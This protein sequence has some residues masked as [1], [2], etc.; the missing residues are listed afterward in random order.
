MSHFPTIQVNLAR[1]MAEI[2]K[3]A[4]FSDTPAPSVTR[5][6]YTTTD[7]AARGYLKTL[8]EEAGF[9]WRTDAMGNTFIRWQGSDP[10]LTA[11]ATGSHI[12]AIPY[13]GRYD[14]VVGVLGGIEALRCLKEGGFVPRRSLEVILFTAE[15]PTRFGVGCIGSRT[16]A[17]LY[18]PSQ[19]RML[20]DKDGIAFDA[21]RHEAG[22]VGD[23]AEVALAGDSY[24]WFVE[25]HIEQAPRL[26][27]AQVPIGVVV[28]VVASTT[29]RVIFKGDGGHA[30]TV[31]M[32]E[33]RDALM[34]AAELALMAEAIAKASGSPDAVT[35]VGIFNVHPGAS[36]SIP[37]QVQMTVDLRDTEMR[38]RDRMLQEIQQSVAEISSRRRVEAEI[39]IFNS[40]P[41]CR[42]HPTIVNA[43]QQAAE[44]LRLAHIPLT[45]RAYHDTVFMGQI[46]PV[47]MIFIPSA[48]GYSHR[49]EEFSSAQEIAQGV[50]VLALTL[51]QLTET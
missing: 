37:S 20:Q 38:V 43:I 11:V 47:A 40:D 4:E 17:G 3:L 30:G 25:L 33:R 28:G 44:Q 35:T 39:E 9:G 22:F 14:G 29:L 49:P 8:V 7:T 31:L 19:L 41:S 27:D 46:C 24:A 21:A 45:S 1:L 23:L 5:I 32:P 36:N 26:E 13:A 51:A 50:A 34:A 2:D 18:T 12:D 48:H 16:L 15:E 6:L 10:S 42:S